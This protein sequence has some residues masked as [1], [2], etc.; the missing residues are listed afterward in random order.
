MRYGASALTFAFSRRRQAQLHQLG[1]FNGVIDGVWGPRSRASLR[2]FKAHNDLPRTDEWTLEVQR[3]LLSG[4]RPAPSGYVHPEPTFEGPGLFVV[5]RPAAGTTLHPL[6]LPDA[7]RIQSRLATLGFY[8]FPA[9]GLWGMASRS[10]LRDFKA[11]RGLSVNDVWDG[12]AERALFR[13]SG[14][15]DIR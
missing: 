3:L 1:F 13:G 9:D 6:N 14:R 11:S 8:R 4:G 5:F 2:Y 10:A 12:A 7:A 15:A